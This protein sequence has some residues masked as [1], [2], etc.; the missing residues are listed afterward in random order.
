M[1]IKKITE[2]SNKLIYLN[3]LKSKSHRKVQLANIK[4]STRQTELYFKK[5][6][7]IIYRYHIF[8]KRILFL[9]FP[10]SFQHILRNTKHVL[11]PESSWLNG[12]ITNQI[13][14]FNY[15]L[16]KQ[17]KRLPFK[18]VK[19]LLQ[20]KKKIDLIV[21]FNLDEN[22]NAIN[23][24]YV[25][26]IPVIG[27]SGNLNISDERVTYKILSE[28]KLINGKLSTSNFFVS[29][30]K[31]VLKKAILTSSKKLQIKYYSYI[32]SKFKKKYRIK[33]PKSRYSHE[34]TRNSK[35]SLRV[36]NFN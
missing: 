31:M 1:K 26:R 22:F 27:V 15:A 18:V 21:V 13:L 6:A 14:R 3:I 20:L 10:L 11:I 16:T 2:R 34:S 36:S 19:L 23:E 29:M 17:Q 24:S 28:F 30:V 5:A 33:R 7:Q 32:K 4:N 35:I 8:N 9:G 25:S 12:I